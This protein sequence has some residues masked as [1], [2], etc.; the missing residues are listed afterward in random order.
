MKSHIKSRNRWGIVVIAVALASAPGQVRAGEDARGSASTVH[1]AVRAAKL[2]SIM[3]LR[4]AGPVQRPVSCAGEEPPRGVGMMITGGAL[5]PAAALMV[6]LGRAFRSLGGGSGFGGGCWHCPEEE[7]EEPAASTR[8]SGGVGLFVFGGVLF[9]TGVALVAVGGH[10]FSE[11][12]KWK[13]SQQVLAPTV[14]R[15]AAGTWTP[16]LVRRF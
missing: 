10:R 15:T 11:W 2:R 16:G 13:Q 5:V 8:S 12:Q 14:G 6:L 7:L 9:L 1:A 3:T 4:E